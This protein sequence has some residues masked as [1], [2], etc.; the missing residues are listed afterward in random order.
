LSQDAGFISLLTLFSNPV[1]GVLVGAVVTAV[2][3]SSSASV[4]ILQAIANTG[5]LPFSSAIPIIMGQ[6]IGTCVTAIISSIGANS[7]AKRVAAVHL[8]F[9]MIGTVLFLALFY[10]LNAI[11]HFPFLDQ[12]ATAF[13]IAVTHS[14]FNMFTVVVLFPFIGRLEWMARRLVKEGKEGERFMVLDDRLLATPTVAVEQC[15]KLTREMAGMARDAFLDAMLLLDRF[16]LKK[17]DAVSKAES[18]IDQYEDRLGE[19]L[20]KISTRPLSLKDSQEVSKLLHILGDFERISDHAVNITEVSDE[21]HSKK[22]QFSPAAQQET[23]VMRQA[24]GEVLTLAVDAFIFSD[25]AKAE[26]VEPLEQ[27]VD[28][29][30]SQIK[31]NHID[32]LKT[33]SCSIELGFVLSDLLTSLERVSDH[34][35]NIAASV[36]EIERRGSLDAHEYVRSLSQGEAGVRFEAVYQDYLA[37]YALGSPSAIPDEGAPAPE[38]GDVT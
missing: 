21:I 10:A 18:Q 24:V 14:V 2:L 13:G 35:S 8:T 29:L 33:G 16:D 20:V 25:L 22:I 12:A 4:G 6:N 38:G 5:A 1:F 23:W 26:Q 31:A 19:Y 9:N 11:F 32:R 3:Q 37:K 30:R 36:I 27:V 15:R 7:N 17:A 28:F 34:C